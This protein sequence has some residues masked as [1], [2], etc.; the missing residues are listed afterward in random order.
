LVTQFRSV[1]IAFDQ[2][3]SY[4]GASTHISHMCKVLSESYGSTLLLTIEGSLTKIDNER[5]KQLCFTSEEENVLKRALLFSAWVKEVLEQQHNLIIGHFRDVW[6]GMAV[7]A[8]P[9]ILPIYEV[10]GLPSMEWPYRYPNLTKATLEKLKHL[11]GRCLKEASLVL[12]PSH[13]IKSHLVSRRVAA[14]KIKVLSNGADLPL[15]SFPRTISGDYIL[16]FGALQAWQGLD[17]LL[18]A[19]RYLEDKVNLKLVICA[20]HTE[21][22]CKAFRKFAEKI[23]VSERIEWRYQLDKDALQEIIQHAYV[24]I[25]PL[26][27]CSRN[28]EQGCSPL[29]IFESMACATPVIAS[30]LPVV[31]EIIDHNQNGILV[32]P[33]RPAE[34]AR[35]IRILLDYPDLRETLSENAKQTIVDQFTWDKIEAN[36]AKLYNQ[37]YDFSFGYSKKNYRYG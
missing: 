14:E 12:T 24:S 35:A 2:H 37:V 36:L 27:E 7:L 19:M 6:G 29:K 3:P 9:H 32:R 20:S 31:R 10:N 8:N 22:H 13:I 16:Y 25:A 30:D 4:K 23:G 17:V 21:H 18:K 28:L 33:G 1:Y 15:S 11:E 26:T 34:L 5:I